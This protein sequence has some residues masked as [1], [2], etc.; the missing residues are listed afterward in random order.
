[1]RTEY[2]PHGVVPLDMSKYELSEYFTTVHPKGN[3]TLYIPFSYVYY[4]DATF[5]P[6]LNKIHHTY[7]YKLSMSVGVSFSLSYKL[8]PATRWANKQIDDFT[9]IIRADNTAKHFVV[10]EKNFADASWTLSEGVGK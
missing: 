9:L 4:F 6:G 1:M 7:R 2:P 8:S 3:D 5:T 10:N